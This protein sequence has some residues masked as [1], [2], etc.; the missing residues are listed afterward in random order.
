MHLGLIMVFILLPTC[1]TLLFKSVSKCIRM[2]IAQFS[3]KSPLNGVASKH[4]RVERIIANRGAG[5]RKQAESLIRRG[6]VVVNG[7]VITSRNDKCSTSADV[8]VDGVCYPAVSF[9]NLLIAINMIVLQAQHMA[10]YH[11]PFGVLRFVAIF[12]IP[13]VNS[14]S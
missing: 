10:I 7:K 13:Y 2:N 9:M 8:Y 5:S 12:L 6:L 11:K 4:Q 3:S 1:Q 14:W